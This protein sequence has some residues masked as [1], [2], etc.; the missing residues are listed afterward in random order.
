[1]K[2]VSN[3]VREVLLTTQVR[4]SVYSDKDIM[5]FHDIWLHLPKRY[6]YLGKLTKKG[7]DKSQYRPQRIATIVVNSVGKYAE[8]SQELLLTKLQEINLAL[9]VG[10]DLDHPDYV[11][12]EHCRLSIGC[13][14]EDGKQFC[15]W[16]VAGKLL[17]SWW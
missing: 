9:K 8:T 4:H 1:M 5:S 15:L 10:L 7:R 2:G 3:L 11:L 12:A 6:N 14:E 17:Q 13:Y 16:N